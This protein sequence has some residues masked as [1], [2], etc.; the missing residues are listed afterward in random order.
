MAVLPEWITIGDLA[1]RSGIATSA[2]RFY[3]SKGLITAERTEGNQRRFRRSTLRRVATIKAAQRVGL[4][5]EE[6]AAALAALPADHNPDRNDWEQLSKSWKA[7]LD[8]R[9]ARLEALRDALTGCIGCGCLSLRSCQLMNR[10]DVS[11]NYGPGDW[12]LDV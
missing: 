6:V 10:D 8:R 1:A 3:E 11:A 5:L 2:L 12:G 9:I 7:G 4:S